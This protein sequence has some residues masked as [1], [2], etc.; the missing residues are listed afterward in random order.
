MNSVSIAVNRAGGPIPASKACGV[1]RQA[2]DKWIDRG[3]LPRTD[4]SGESNYA[5]KLAAAA[6]AR[7]YPFDPREL[8]DKTL[9][10][11]E[12][13]KPNTAAA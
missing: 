11:I 4:Y 10:E 3:C 6:A 8:L 1:S 2:V 13:P 12:D 9:V 5:E 7:G